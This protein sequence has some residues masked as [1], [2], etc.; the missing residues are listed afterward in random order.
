[1][2]TKTSFVFMVA[3]LA[4]GTLCLAANPQMGTWKL[5]EKKSKITPG[6]Q[7][8]TTVTYQSM[9]FQT[10]VTGDGVDGKGNPIHSEWMGAFDG[11]DH[12]VKGNGVEQTRSYRK[13]DDRTLEFVSKRAGNALVQGRIVVAADGKSRTVKTDGTMENGKK[14]HNVAVYDKQ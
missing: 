12:P 1:M 5:N 13:I 8:N 6:T 9:L 3:W 11:K 4:A 7:K 2:K 10:K 14:F